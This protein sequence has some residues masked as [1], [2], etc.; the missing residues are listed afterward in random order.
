MK[1]TLPFRAD[2]PLDSSATGRN[3]TVP[4]HADQTE[5]RGTASANSAASLST[6]K[7]NNLN[8]VRIA[9]ACQVAVYHALSH[10]NVG[11]GS[12]F[13]Y[14]V[15]LFPGV[16]IF[17]FVSGLLISKS[18]DREPDMRTYGRNRIL[19]LYPG[20]WTAFFVGVAFAL[21]AGFRP[22]TSIIE[23]VAWVTG[24]L[25]FVQFYTPSF[26]RSYGTGVLNGSLWTI[27]VE[28]QFYAFLPLFCWMMRSQKRGSLKRNGALLS[29]ILCFAVANRWYIGAGG[30]LTDRPIMKFI[31]VS[32]VPWLY[33]FVVGALVTENF[34]RIYPLVRRYWALVALLCSLILGASRPLF[35]FAVDNRLNPIVFL[36][37]AGIT[38]VCSFC[39]PPILLSVQKNWDISYG[40]YL[41]HAP[42]INF[43]LFR[44]SRGVPSVITTLLVTPFLAILSWRLIERPA[45]RLK[46]TYGN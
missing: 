39:L 37:L 11:T 16:P 1:N 28:L 2:R 9:A 14:I 4:E 12:Q 3:E 33:M 32:F 15:S 10:F 40:I 36:A 23:M 21:I 25:T 18:L 22:H 43:L 42:I 38:L 20:L 34:S 24:Q 29:S 31:G 45:L 30:Q 19:R 26:M 35:G 6:W 41:Y 5:L 7:Q 17:F 46:A 44:N 27:V 13:V 8:F